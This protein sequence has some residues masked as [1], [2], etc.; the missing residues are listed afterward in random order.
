M[1]NLAVILYVIT[2]TRMVKYWC[3]ILQ[4]ENIVVA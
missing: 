4:S 2:Q 1:V 3:R